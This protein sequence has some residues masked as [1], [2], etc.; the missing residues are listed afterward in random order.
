MRFTRQ[1]ISH[2]P[3]HYAQTGEAMRFLPAAALGVAASVLALAACDG[4]GS[5]APNETPSFARISAQ[6][7]YTATLSCNAAATDSRSSVTVIF[8]GLG[9]NYL[10]CRPGGL[11][12]ATAT[13][14]SEF[15]WAIALEDRTEVI[16]KECPGTRKNNGF[17]ISSRTGEFVC[18]DAKTGFSVTLTVAPS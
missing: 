5:T 10:F 15:W 7:Q 11:K 14:F 3:I 8:A 12:Q 2:P 16:V 13:S 9:A 6:T 18:K 4:Q 1:V 17:G